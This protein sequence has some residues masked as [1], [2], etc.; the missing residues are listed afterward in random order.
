MNLARLRRLF[1]N[2]TWS[3]FRPPGGFSWRYLGTLR[4]R[5]VVVYRV[6]MLAGPGDDDFT[7]AWMVLYPNGSAEP[8]YT[9]VNHAR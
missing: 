6:A 3:A 2:Y 4:G 5:D 8:L 9:L 1:P 7:T